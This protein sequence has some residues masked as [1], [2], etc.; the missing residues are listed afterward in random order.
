MA[1]RKTLVFALVAFAFAVI[2]ALAGQAL[3]R[4]SSPESELHEMLHHQL[5]L[6]AKQES[7]IEVIEQRFAV[8]RKALELELRADNAPVSY[9]HLD[10]YKRQRYRSPPSGAAR[11][12]RPRFCHPH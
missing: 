10:V 6:D 5:E 8:R 4:S 3:I 1:W 2:G 9:T 12:S 7:Q 11:M